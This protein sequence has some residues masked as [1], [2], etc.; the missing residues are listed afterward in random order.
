MGHII[1]TSAAFVKS[2]SEDAGTR[3]GIALSHSD[4]LD[5][6][7]DDH[8]FVE[9]VTSEDALRLA[10]TDYGDV[11]GDLL[12]ALGTTDVKGM[13]H[14]SQRFLMELLQWIVLSC[15]HCRWSLAASS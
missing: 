12:Y 1:M 10:S 14:L 2:A 7:G 3:S 15:Q 6:L 9:K 8:P 4:I 5:H 13:P 11:V